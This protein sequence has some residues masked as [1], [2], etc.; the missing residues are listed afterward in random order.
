[1]YLCKECFIETHYPY[2]ELTRKEKEEI[3]NRAIAEH[4]FPVWK[5]NQ[6]GSKCVCERCK[7]ETEVIG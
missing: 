6:D 5:Y 4:R 2:P 1:M 3:V 7:K